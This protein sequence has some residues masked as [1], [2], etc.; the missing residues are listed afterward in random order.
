MY[1]L[2]LE[3]GWLN[4]KRRKVRAWLIIVMLSVCL[5]LMLSLQGLYLGMVNQ[6]SNN[7]IDTETGDIAIYAKSYRL[8]RDLKNSIN[9]SKEIFKYLDNQEGVIS[10]KSNV[11]QEGTVATAKKTLM[12]RLVGINI[13]ENKELKDL[14]I[15]GEFGF[16]KRDKKVIMG[17]RLAKKL[18]IKIGSRVVFS[19]QSLNNEIS[20]ISLRLN[21]I[22]KTNNP[23]IDKVA[24]YIPIAKSQIFTGI[25]GISKITI[26]LDEYADRDKILNSLKKEFKDMDIKT[27]SELAPAIAQMSVMIDI[28][29]SIIFGIVVFVVFIGVSGVMVVSVLERIREFGMMMAI[30]VKYKQIRQQ[31][32]FESLILSFGGFIIGSILGYMGLWYL[33]KYG[34][35]LSAFSEGLEQFGMSSIIYGDIQISYFINALW[36]IIIAGLL[37]VT[38]PLIKLKKMNPVEVIQGDA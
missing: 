15:S 35:D 14:I 18:G 21:G 20:S 31:L 3:M 29:N 30:G 34:L 11:I 25:K 28:F 2:I 4:I 24:I 19:G 27:W 9:N 22:V 36:A 12:G 33:R 26:R 32:I 5:G 16:G 23:N 6:M 1:K 38:I 37:A 13:E 10:Y 7:M 8:N 17:Y